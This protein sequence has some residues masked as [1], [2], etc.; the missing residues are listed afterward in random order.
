MYSD[1]AP[2]RVCGSDVELRP[3]RIEGVNDPDGPTDERVC[4]NQ[5]CE[6]NAGSGDRRP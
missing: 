3:A 1:Y 4:L 6:T 5:E 2:C